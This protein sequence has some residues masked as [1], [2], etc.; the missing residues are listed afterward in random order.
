MKAS[1]LTSDKL[2]STALTCSELKVSKQ[3]AS[4]GLVVSGSQSAFSAFSAF[5]AQS[6]FIYT[7]YEI[8]S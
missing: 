6:A 2:L 1:L 4:V 5:S 3:V 8:Y 7:I